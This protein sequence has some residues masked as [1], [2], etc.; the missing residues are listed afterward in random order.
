[1]LHTPLATNAVELLRGAMWALGAA[2]RVVGPELWIMGGSHG[3]YLTAAMQRRMQSDQTLS[4][5]WNVTG[6]VR[7]SRIHCPLV[8]RQLDFCV[9]ANGSSFTPRLWTCREKCSHC[10][11]ERRLIRTRGTSSQS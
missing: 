3:G 10:S 9:A 7:R 11:S 2:G 6:S 5:L 1:M 4:R 8:A